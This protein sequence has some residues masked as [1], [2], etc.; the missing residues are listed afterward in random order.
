MPPPGI[1]PRTTRVVSLE[2]PQPFAAQDV[3]DAPRGS[4]PMS[5]RF[6]GARPGDRAGTELDDPFPGKITAEKT[7][8]FGAV[9]FQASQMNHPCRPRRARFRCS[10][11]LHAQA[12][13]GGGAADPA[14]VKGKP[15][16][17]GQPALSR[18]RLCV[19]LP[20]PVP[21]AYSVDPPSGP[22]HA[23]GPSAR[24]EN[25]AEGPW[26][27]PDAVAT[28][29]ES[30]ALSTAPRG[31]A[32]IPA[33]LLTLSASK[34]GSGSP[35]A[36]RTGVPSKDPR[37]SPPGAVSEGPMQDAENE[38]APPALNVAKGE[39]GADAGPW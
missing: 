36:T 22:A 12:E 24:F 29:R 9:G 15:V 13:S 20:E 7:L 26:A 35:Q 32:N 23:E 30:A 2:R 25:A 6:R 11:V 1:L 8:A 31:R 19:I 21:T 37:E 3:I 28:S 27:H 17:A 10:H 5:R 18:P 4:G 33:V 38:N 34:Y 39:L 16:L 14:T